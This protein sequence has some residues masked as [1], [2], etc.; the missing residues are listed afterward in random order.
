MP[1][2]YGCGAG[3]QVWRRCCGREERFEGCIDTDGDNIHDKID[4]CPE[5]AG[6]IKFNGCPDTDKDGMPD[7]WE[8]A[9][10]GDLN[11]DGKGDADGDGYTDLEEFLNQVDN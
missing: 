7:A 5:Q 9:K 11:R 3:R 6:E 4:Q 10:F 2:L 8:I 1:H